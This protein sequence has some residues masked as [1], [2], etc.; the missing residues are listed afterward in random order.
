MSEEKYALTLGVGVLDHLGIRLYSDTPAV[1]S[2]VV[3]N[4]WDADAKRVEV[5]VKNDTITIS[6]D[7]HG[8]SL[9]DINQRYLHV[10]YDR[11]KES[12]LSEEFHRPVMGRKGIGK[13][14]LLSIAETIEVHTVKKLENGRLDSN[15]LRMSVAA[16]QAVQESEEGT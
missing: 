16:I 2:E 1:L 10:G 9:E 3:A 8:M 6:D 11:R 15:A 7:G 4:A 14:S 13:L 5:E 12:A